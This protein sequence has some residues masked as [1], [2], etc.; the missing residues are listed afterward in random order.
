MPNMFRTFP[1]ATPSLK[2]NTAS[3]I[4]NLSVSKPYKNSFGYPCPN[5]RVHMFIRIVSF[6]MKTFLQRI[7][8][9]MILEQWFH[10]IHK[11]SW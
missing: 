11:S 5:N 7:Y 2:H 1:F 4:P 9:R 10:C 3:Y 8:T 6:P